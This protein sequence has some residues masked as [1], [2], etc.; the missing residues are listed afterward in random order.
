MD[1]QGGENHE[2]TIATIVAVLVLSA[3][4]VLSGCA[5]AQTGTEQGATASLKMETVE[6]IRLVVVS[7]NPSG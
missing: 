3:A 4:L 7:I 5:S 2:K 6:D 1:N